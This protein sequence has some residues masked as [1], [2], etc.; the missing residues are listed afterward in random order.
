MIESI[1]K[2]KYSDNLDD[3]YIKKEATKKFIQKE[4]EI[5]NN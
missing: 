5:R 2:E 1:I 3:F 4:I